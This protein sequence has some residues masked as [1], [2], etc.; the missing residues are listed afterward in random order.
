MLHRFWASECDK[1]GVGIKGDALICFST[2]L[3]S[4]W[5][6]LFEMVSDCTLEAAG[7]CGQRLAEY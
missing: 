1:C 4:S 2:R 7:H 5:A 6:R 3:V